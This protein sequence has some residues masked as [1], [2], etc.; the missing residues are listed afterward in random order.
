MKTILGDSSAPVTAG[1]VTV[2]QAAV[3]HLSSMQLGG[4]LSLV[5]HPGCS[6]QPDAK[7]GPGRRKA[8]CQALQE[9]LCPRLPTQSVNTRALTQAMTTLTWIAN[10]TKRSTRVCPG[11]KCRIQ[12]GTE[13]CFFFF[14]LVVCFY[15]KTGFLCV[16]ALAGLRLNLQTRLALNS[17][18]SACLFP[19]CWN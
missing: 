3:L 10:K 5:C 14:F 17:W 1:S 16:V 4:A 13:V 2:P 9:L 18:R 15:F 8:F 7:G 11:P 12:K 19:E 6:V